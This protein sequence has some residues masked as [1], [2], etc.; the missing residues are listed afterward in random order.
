MSVETTF[1]QDLTDMSEMLD[2]LRQFSEKVLS[3]M[4]ARQSAGSTITLR[5]YPPN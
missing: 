4:N 1:E 2:H 3:K 5:C